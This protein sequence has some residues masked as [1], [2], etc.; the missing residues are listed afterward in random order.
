MQIFGVTCYESVCCGAVF[1]RL[2]EEHQR[3]G[4]TAVSLQL[5][6]QECGH[7]K[8]RFK[9]SNFCSLYQFLG[10]YSGIFQ[11][12][13]LS[14]S[15]FDSIDSLAMAKKS[16]FCLNFFQLFLFLLHLS[17]V[18]IVSTYF[19]CALFV[20]TA[21]PIAYLSRQS[22]R[23]NHIASILS[24]TRTVDGCYARQWCNVLALAHT[25]HYESYTLYCRI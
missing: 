14:L 18:S 16:S 1:C 6:M 20:A 3:R 13:V 11:K 15:L 4:S 21:S 7:F 8:A 2:T 23:G 25:C 10:G 17:P 5:C 19:F 9:F 24:D 22:T 12:T